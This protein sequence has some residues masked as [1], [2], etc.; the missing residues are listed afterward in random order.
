MDRVCGMYKVQ[1]S[2]VKSWRCCLCGFRQVVF[3][4]RQALLEQLRS[5]TDAA[6]TLHLAATV[7]FSVFT[8]C[9]IHAPG[10]CVPQ[11][12]ALLKTHL[13]EDKHKALVQCQG[14]L[15]SVTL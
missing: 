3:A 7:L 5:E 1:D 8:Q 14:E 9:M 6:M 12:I 2:G 15:D 13:D 11:V 10:K 4:H